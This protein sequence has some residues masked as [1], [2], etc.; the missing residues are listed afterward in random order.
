[1]PDINALIESPIK[2]SFRVAQIQ[3]MF[4]VAPAPVVRHEIKASLPIEGK[5]WKIGLV[6]GPSGSGKTTIGR[7]AFPGA[8]FHEGYDWPEDAAVVDGFPSHLEGREITQALSSVGFSSPPHWLKRFSHLSN[9]QQFRCELARL[10]LERVDTVVCDEFTS[11]IDRDAAKV[12]S[13]AVAKAIRAR[14]AAPRFVALSCHYDVID[15]LDPDWVFDTASMTFA[16]RSLRRRPPIVLR[17]HEATRDAWPLFKPHHY[18]S[19]EINSS[20]RCFVA[21]WRDQ[22]VGFTSWMHF[23][24]PRVKNGKRAHRLVVLPD[25]QGIGIGNALAAW[26]GAHL[27]AAGCRF[28]LATGHP[29]LIR[30]C[31]ASPLWRTTNL[32]HANPIRSKTHAAKTSRATSAAARLT[33][34]FEYIGPP[35]TYSA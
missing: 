24:H 3:G 32:G 10:S 1:M 20:A 29:A 12:S 35:A 8:L 9:G 17:I 21:T 15:W 33:G 19:G 6:V 5:P 4:D 34:S 25:Y 31:H 26:S 16:W 14:P 27:K 30:H 18:M 2:T 23:P 22:P 13:A 28:Y 7:R 11:V